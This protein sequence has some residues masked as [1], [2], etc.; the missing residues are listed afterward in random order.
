MRSSRLGRRAEL[1]TQA[2]PAAVEL[3]APSMASCCCSGVLLLLLV[4]LS[5]A[6]SWLPAG[7]LMLLLLGRVLA[8]ASRHGQRP[9]L[10][11]KERREEE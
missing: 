2:L 9:T 7:V 1:A 10:L 8:A 11:T 4:A 3:V 6:S 5:M